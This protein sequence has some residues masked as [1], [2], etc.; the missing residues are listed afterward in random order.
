MNEGREMN[1]KLLDY[2]DLDLQ[3]LLVVLDCSRWKVMTFFALSLT[4]RWISASKFEGFVSCR[5]QR[6]KQTLEHVASGNQ[7]LEQCID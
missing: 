1:L 6:Q 2:L 4:T 5:R 3:L 7:R